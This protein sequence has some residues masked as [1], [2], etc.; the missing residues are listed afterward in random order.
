M[1]LSQTRL[2]AAHWPLQAPVRA[3]RCQ[4]LV[5]RC[6]P[7]RRTPNADNVDL[8]TACGKLFRVSVLAITDPGDSDIIKTTE[9]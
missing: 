3:S 5:L 6:A 9:A 7:H 8:G 2:G 4:P 1:Q